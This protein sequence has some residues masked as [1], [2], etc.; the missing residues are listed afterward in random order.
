MQ[1]HCHPW[2]VPGGNNKLL[3]SYPFRPGK[4]VQTQC[5]P[6]GGGGGA[7]QEGKQAHS[8]QKGKLQVAW[9]PQWLS[10]WD[11]GTAG[12]QAPGEVP[13]PPQDP[14]PD[15]YC[16]EPRRSSRHSRCSHCTAVSRGCRSHWRTGS[17]HPLHRTLERK[18]NDVRI[19]VCFFWVFL[20]FILKIGEAHKEEEKLTLLL[21]DL[22]LNPPSFTVINFPVAPQTLHC[23]MTWE[24][25]KHC[26]P[27]ES[28]RK[29]PMGLQS[30]SMELKRAAPSIVQLLWGQYQMA[31]FFFN[32]WK[33][34]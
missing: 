16:N 15:T 34:F 20:F 18:K 27:R 24:Q 2:C 4:G 21:T 11:N 17:S 14:A 8:L 29:W 32:N 1:K 3:S 12:F 30:Y 9:L 22:F 28:K 13:V 26:W 33:L 19:M 10:G 5:C 25:H 31:V 23:E 7:V 6:Q